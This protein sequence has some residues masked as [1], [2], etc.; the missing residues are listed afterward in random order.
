VLHLLFIALVTAPD[1]RWHPGIGDP[2]LI[3]WLTVVAYAAAT[4]FSFRALQ[5]SRMGAE[6]LQA[7]APDEAQNQRNLAKLWLLVT[8]IMLLLGIN[9]QLDLQTL[10]TEILRDMAHAQGWWEERRKYQVV[11]ILFILLVGASGT[12]LLA[13]V[14][15]KVLRRVL[16]AVVGLGVIA[17]FV[18]IRAASFHHIDILLR[19]GP[20]RLNWIL[21]LGGIGMVAVSAY[22]SAAV[23]RGATG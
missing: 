23:I 5:A 9:K 14:L 6:K 12:A 19:S 3:G 16:G 20:V 2:T 11:F 7:I 15:R 10:F 18:V 8:L 17:S 13:Y 21:E 1:G 4:Y 22:R